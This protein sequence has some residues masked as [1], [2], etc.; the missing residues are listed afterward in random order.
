MWE[1]VKVMRI[2][3]GC[4][5][6]LS[7]AL[8]LQ[9]TPTFALAENVAE[10]QPKEVTNQAD[11]PSEAVAPEVNSDKSQV[12]KQVDDKGVQNKGEVPKK[13]MLKSAAPSELR[14]ESEPAQSDTIEINSKE[15][16]LK[17]YNTETGSLSPVLHDEMVYGVQGK[18][19]N[20]N[21]DIVVSSDEIN[22]QIDRNKR[23]KN[24]EHSFQL[25]DSNFHGNNHKITITQGKR[26]IY[27][28]FGS[29]CNL[30]SSDGEKTIDNLNIEYKGDV[31]GSGF[32]RY[33]NLSL[34][35]I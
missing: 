17:F 31:K 33:I 18:T 6:A 14:T 20:L 15:D 13:S 27:P 7:L 24:Y 30:S 10:G 2:K 22:M 32:A 3:K 19:I 29:I 34:I 21:T 5:I 1:R 35:H 23:Y 11:G 12:S 4:A 26:T 28:L 25:V 16:F 8:C 9:F